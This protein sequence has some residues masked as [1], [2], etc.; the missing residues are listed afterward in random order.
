VVTAEAGA[1]IELATDVHG[2]AV[3]LEVEERVRGLLLA[4]R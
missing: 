1:V 2:D 4:V 3:R